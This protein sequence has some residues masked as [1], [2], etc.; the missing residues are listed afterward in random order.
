MPPTYTTYEEAEK[1]AL[2]A[3]RSV[4]LP[5][6]IWRSGDLFRVLDERIKPTVGWPDAS[7]I[8]RP[9][10]I[11]YPNGSQAGPGNEAE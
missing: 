9:C 11:I 4:G 2:R 8:H 10:A 5:H 3:A 6:I 7:A 1:R